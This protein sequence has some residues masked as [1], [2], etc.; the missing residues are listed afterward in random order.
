MAVANKYQGKPVAFIAVNSGSSLPSIAGYVKEHQINWPV[1]ADFDRSFEKLAKIREISLQNIWQAAVILPDGSFRMANAQD[2]A[3][4]AELALAGA[5]WN[6]DPAEIPESLK[7]VWQGVEF[8]AYAGVA[9]ALKKNLVSRKPDVKAAA[10]K[11]MAY[12]AEQLKEQH[13]QAV[14]ASEAGDKWAAYKALARLQA[15]FKGYEL[16]GDVAQKHNEL[17]KDPKV[18]GEL[19]A[20][21][22]LETALKALNGPTDSARRRGAAQ[23]QQLVRDHPDTE[24]AAQAQ[25]LLGPAKS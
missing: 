25:K 22:K 16:P 23:L 1:L 5:K 3:A 11:L 19:A 10:E 6:V 24:A 18:T 13:A 9:A 4:S 17:A 2:L 21:K 20:Q 8:G 7:P 12:V 14:K 15:D